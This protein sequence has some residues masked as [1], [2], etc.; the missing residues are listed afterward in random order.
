MNLV[1]L[2][3]GEFGILVNLGSDQAIYFI[4]NEIGPN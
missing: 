2:G 4:F 3:F 1:N